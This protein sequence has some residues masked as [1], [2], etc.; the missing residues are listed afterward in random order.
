MK[1][2]LRFL[3]AIA[4]VSSLIGCESKGFK[5]ERQM[6]RAQKQ[7]EAV[8]KNAKETP[9]FQ[10]NKAREAYQD[11]IKKYPDSLFAVQSQLGI[12]RLSL[13]MGEF[14]RARDEFKKLLVKCDQRAGICAG[15]DLIIGNSY[16]ME[17]H[18]DLALNQYKKIMQEFPFT[19]QSLEL[20]L[21]IIM[22]YKRIGDKTS[23][24]YFVD[25]AVA[26]YLSLESRVAARTDFMAIKGGAEQIQKKAAY[27]LENLI[28]KAYLA[29]DR[30]LDAINSLDKMIRDFPQAN[31]QDALFAKAFLY[32]NKLNDKPKAKEV[33]AGIIKNYPNSR[34]AKQAQAILKKI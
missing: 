4:L 29:G 1:N 23:V 6:W 16:E 10:V 26:Y 3:L 11:I 8:Y 2:S 17:E 34:L 9:P 25:E 24:N 13:A 19:S 28:T 30:W 5:A 33:L 22:H 7:A 20:P 12:G 27:L 18:W 32:L 14:Q 31:A 15:A 21:Y